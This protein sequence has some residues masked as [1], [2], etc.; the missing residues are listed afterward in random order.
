MKKRA[1]T[2]KIINKGICII[3]PIKPYHLFVFLKFLKTIYPIVLTLIPHK[4][5][6]LITNQLIMN[7]LFFGII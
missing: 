4:R 7:G 5:K 3:E 6:A 1:G 2:A